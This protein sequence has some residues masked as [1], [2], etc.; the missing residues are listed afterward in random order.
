[1]KAKEKADKLMKKAIEM[2]KKADEMIEEQKKTEELEGEDEFPGT[3]K[4]KEVV[5][6]SGPKG[7]Y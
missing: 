4:T 7:G 1:M 5:D 3:M 2:H 6:L